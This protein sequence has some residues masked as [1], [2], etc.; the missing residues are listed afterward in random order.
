[1]THKW[2][3]IC[4]GCQTKH[5]ITKPKNFPKNMDNTQNW[6]MKCDE[7]GSVMQF[8]KGGV[9]GAYVCNRC[10]NVYEV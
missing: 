3:A 1:M 5:T 4:D 9:C 2:Q 7:C 8:H 6:K 10:N